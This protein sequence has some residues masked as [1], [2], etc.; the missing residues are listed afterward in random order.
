MHVQIYP[1][2][3]PRDA[4]DFSTRAIQLLESERGR[5][6]TPQQKA[7]ILDAE[8][9]PTLESMLGT[10]SMLQGVVPAELARQYRRE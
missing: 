3:L 8:Q 4:V 2:D 5:K 6:L 9:L 10:G 1:D 7:R